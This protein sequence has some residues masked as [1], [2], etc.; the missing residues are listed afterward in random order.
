[1]SSTK[2]SAQYKFS[3]YYPSSLK[4][5]EYSEGH[6]ASDITFEALDYSQGFQVYAMP[7][8]E[9]QGR[10]KRFKLDEPSGVM[11]NA[12]ATSVGGAQATSFVGYNSTM[13]T[14]SEVWFIHNGI[15][16]EVATY[17][18]LDAWLQPITQSWR[19]I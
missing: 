10:V 15:L 3:L 18:E 6:G 19:F 7:Y 5:T 11:H 14:T 9:R 13:G 1:M 12:T 2:N 17:K 16:Y 8:D 4:V